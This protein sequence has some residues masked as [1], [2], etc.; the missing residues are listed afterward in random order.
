M[1]DEQPKEPAKYFRW[2]ITKLVNGKR[3]TAIYNSNIGKPVEKEFALS[4]PYVRKWLEDG[5]FVGIGPVP[6]W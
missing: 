5:E 6:A 1:Q 4:S 3:E 2:Q